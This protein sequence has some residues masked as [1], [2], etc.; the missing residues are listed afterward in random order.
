[1]PPPLE[2]LPRICTRQK[3]YVSQQMAGVGSGNVVAPS[4]SVANHV[5]GFADTTGKIL[6]DLGAADSAAT[7][8]AFVKRDSAGRAKFVDPAA[9]QDVATKNYADG[10]YT[11]N[12][13]GFVKL[14][15]GIIIQWG[16]ASI[17][18][19]DNTVSFQNSF[20]TSPAV[21]LSPV[22]SSAGS[23]KS[24]TASTFIV[25]VTAPSTFN[26]VA[27]GY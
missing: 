27:V 14:P 9:A 22:G 24:V 4:S 19:G 12:N 17:G 2:D 26:W 3:T 10:T 7:V 18:A 11:K 21:V 5:T 1:M 15:A 25:A 8:S 13:P 16:I 6:V 23:I 20:T